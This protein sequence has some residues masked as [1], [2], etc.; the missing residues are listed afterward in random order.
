MRA[1]Q[2]ATLRA[3]FRII[4]KPLGSDPTMSPPSTTGVLHV[5]PSVIWKGHYRITTKLSGWIRIIPPPFTTGAK[6]A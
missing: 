5:M 4:A 6:H 1:E 2:T 3:R